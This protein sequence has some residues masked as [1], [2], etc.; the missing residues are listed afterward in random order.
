MSDSSHYAERWVLLVM[1]LAGAGIMFFFG[2]LIF[3]GILQGVSA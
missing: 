3:I 1:L 2:A